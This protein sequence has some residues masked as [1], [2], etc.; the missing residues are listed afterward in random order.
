[1]EN[2]LVKLAIENEVHCQVMQFR[3]GIWREKL[4][5]R[6]EFATKRKLEVWPC[7][8]DGVLKAVI[9]VRERLTR[10]GAEGDE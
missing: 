1:M 3:E 9:E 5:L 4:E 8:E 2:S 10:A 7:D 6:G